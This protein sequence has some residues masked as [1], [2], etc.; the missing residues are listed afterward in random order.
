MMTEEAKKEEKRNVGVWRTGSSDADE[1]EQQQGRDDDGVSENDRVVIQEQQVESAGSAPAPAVSEPASQGNEAGD[2]SGIRSF[3]IGSEELMGAV[4]GDEGVHLSS[5]LT[6]SASATRRSGHRQEDSE[7]S[8][9]APTISESLE[10]RAARKLKED[11][12]RFKEHMDDSAATRDLQHEEHP[13]SDVHADL[14]RSE[15]PSSSPSISQV[16]NPKNYSEEGKGSKK[17]NPSSPFEISVTSRPNSNTA[18]VS[19]SNSSEDNGCSSL[20][21]TQSSSLLTLLAAALTTS[22]YVV[23]AT[24]NNVSNLDDEV[25]VNMNGDGS[26]RDMTLQQAH[27]PPAAVEAASQWI[28]IQIPPESSQSATESNADTS[29][30]NHLNRLRLL[31]LRVCEDFSSSNTPGTHRVV[32]EFARTLSLRHSTPSTNAIAEP[33]SPDRVSQ[34]REDFALRSARSMGALSPNQ[35]A[36]VGPQRF[37][38][39]SSSTST[40]RMTSSEFITEEAEPPSTVE[41][42]LDRDSSFIFPHLPPEDDDVASPVNVIVNNESS[43]PLAPGA[44]SHSGRAFGAAPAWARQQNTRQQSHRSSRRRSS[45]SNQITGSV[46]RLFNRFSSSQQQLNYPN[47]PDYSASGRNVGQDNDGPITAEI[48]DESEMEQKMRLKLMEEARESTTEAAVVDM[49]N[50]AWR[51]KW[52]WA[53]VIFAIALVGAVIALTIKPD[54]SDDSS[55]RDISMADPTPSPSSYVPLPP[56]LQT[57][58]ARGYVRCGTEGTSD[59]DT[60]TSGTVLFEVDLCRA[61]SAAIFGNSS[62]TEVLNVGFPDR[63]ES[64][65]SRTVDA[66]ISRSTHTFGRDVLEGSSM[67]GFAFSAPYLYD[68]LGFAGKEFAVACSDRLDS[69]FG[70]CRFVRVCVSDGSTHFP[71]LAGRLSVE[72]LVI[73]H[74]TSDVLQG[75]VDGDCNV[76]AGELNTLSKRLLEQFEYTGEYVIGQN[77][78]TREPLGIVTLDYDYEWSLFVNVMMN[79]IMEAERRGI[80]KGSSMEMPTI[81]Y[82][83]SSFESMLQ[84]SVGAVGNYGDMYDKWVATDLPRS[85]LNMMVDSIDPSCSNSSGGLLYSFPFGTIS[86]DLESESS[87]TPGPTLKNIMENGFVTCGIA[88]SRAGFLSESDAGESVGFEV[89]LC[90]G[91]AASIFGVE[92]ENSFVVKALP[93]GA[94]V[95]DHIASLH[96]GSID[97]L[98]GRSIQSLRTR[99]LDVAVSI[100]YFYSPD[101]EEALVVASSSTDVSWSDYLNWIIMTLIYA[102]ENPIIMPEVSLYGASFSEMLRNVIDSVGNYAD[103]YDRHLELLIPRQL[104][105]NRL[106]LAPNGPQHN[107]LLIPE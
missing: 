65:K 20:S 86:M 30:D 60:I 27:S 52:F 24:K 25:V 56:T 5:S 54:D 40:H 70:E 55:D 84:N 3:D 75:F 104:T 87:I 28:W 98:L 23:L 37:S 11:Q 83:G 6:S 33:S 72:N 16:S 10:K 85:A 88:R 21:Q 107:P 9:T 80:S 38:S 58:R 35:Q 71:F 89:D 50:P 15:A 2:A 47:D 45:T 57:I 97:I 93:D 19:I 14:T 51:Q 91:I 12:A 66:I 49:A 64:L 53:F 43:T 41:Q 29:A 42:S 69:Y 31:L 68:G 103:M 61:L 46:S 100:P 22:G 90:R 82:F 13:R 48:V 99:L 34:M 1:G 67:T 94:A 36:G 92:K 44:Y 105:C 8:T 7:T 79:G 62:K 17:N 81:P 76:I 78:F 39:L 106:N 95:G 73:Q 96:D 26:V 102:E 18:Y 101:K 77:L 4:A 32:Q 63:W 74:S 59:E